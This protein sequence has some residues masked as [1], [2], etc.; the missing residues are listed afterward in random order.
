MDIYMYRPLDETAIDLGPGR[1]QEAL[2]DIHFNVSKKTEV[3]PRRKAA[4]AQATVRPSLSDGWEKKLSSE[5]MMPSYQRALRSS[6]DIYPT[7]TS[8]S[9]RPHMAFYHELSRPKTTPSSARRSYLNERAS[10]PSGSLTARPSVD[11]PFTHHCSDRPTCSSGLPTRPDQH[12]SGATPGASVLL[13][14]LPAAHPLAASHSWMAAEQ[15]TTSGIAGGEGDAFSDERRPQQ[16]CAAGP[17]S[18]AKLRAH[19]A[20]RPRLLAHRPARPNTIEHVGGN[21]RIG[22]GSSNLGGEHSGSGSSGS[23]HE[24]KGKSGGDGMGAGE[25]LQSQLEMLNFGSDRLIS[26][27]RVGVAQLPVAVAHTQAYLDGL[28]MLPAD[29]V[30]HLGYLDGIDGVKLSNGQRRWA[31][32]PFAPVSGGGETG[33]GAKPGKLQPPT[34]ESITHTGM[35]LLW[36]ASPSSEMIAGYELEVIDVDA[37]SGARPWRRVHKGQRCHRKL[38]CA[39]SVAG[40]KARVRA[41]NSSGKGEWSEP[42]AFFRLPAIPAPSRKPIEEIPSAWVLLD[43]GGLEDLRE[44]VVDSARLQRTRAELLETMFDHREVIKLAFRYYALAGVSS[45]D[46]DPNTMTMVQFGNFCRGAK[47]LEPSSTRE[48]ISSSDIDR[49]F[50]RAVRMLPPAGKGSDNAADGLAPALEA[51]G[52]RVSKDW[53]KVRAAV[54]AT[55]LFTRGANLM[56]QQQFVGGLMRLAA[57]MSQDEASS[58]GEKLSALC[59]STVAPHVHDELRLLEDDMTLKMRSR[60]MGAVLESHHEQLQQVPY[61]K[62]APTPGFRQ[63][64][65]LSRRL[66]CYRFLLPTLQP[67]RSPPRRAASPPR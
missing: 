58:L 12:A 60:P 7:G 1:P 8:G 21:G 9:P 16:S 38:P 41:Y 56:S 17:L 35:K 25:C 6:L 13:P 64:V 43:V 27:E 3:E 48:A 32:W 44:D 39:R 59:A 40:V 54:T 28:E 62:G 31:A 36:C 18:Y 66:P 14:S 61:K 4:K 22:S 63:T 29:R 23:R 34:A 57:F 67:T 52:V 45:V 51:S 24:C 33:R 55:S 19:A 11:R 65:N 49:I 5:Y 46:D 15:D 37:L 20:R 30:L 47:M 53:K 10:P 50:L 42:S 2:H 26:G